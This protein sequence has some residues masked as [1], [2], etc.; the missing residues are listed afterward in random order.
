MSETPQPIAEGNQPKAVKDKNCEYCGQAFT[1]S[2]LGRHLD[3]YIKEKNPKP[4][5]GIHDVDAIR[6]LRGNITRRQPRGS[7]GARR[8][9]STPGSTPKPT[10]GKTALG[11]DSDSFKADSA[12]NKYPFAASWEA[13]GVIKDTPGK[14]AWDASAPQDANKRSGLSRNVSKQMAQ[15]AQFDIKQ[16]LTDAMDTAKAAELALRELVSSWRAAKQQTDR[17][18]T[19][20]D[21]DPLALDFPSLAIHCLL[22]PPTLFSSTQ[23]PT[24][25]SWSLSTPGKREYV[26]L[27][28]FFQEEFKA[29]KATHVS[30][31]TAV[32]GEMVYPSAFAV[33][34]SLP[35]QRKSEL[36]HLELARGVGRMHKQIDKM[37]DEQHNLKQ[38]N[39]NLKSHIDQLNRL[40]Q[41][42][43][44]KILTPSTIPVDRDVI[45]Y[46]E[47]SVIGSRLVGYEPEDRHLDLSTVVAKSIERW[48]S[49]IASTREAASGMPAQRPLEQAAAQTPAANSQTATS[50]A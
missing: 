24:S 45:A 31:T 22:P 17:N 9:N 36:W 39:A 10:A 20:F 16:K 50:A 28:A 47:Q 14:N 29:W 44:Y 23:H 11:Q 1:S 3:L 18:S 26:A 6:K 49:V 27:Q 34:E 8:D 12:A 7:L 25:T 2:S 32:I 48:K 5:D 21:F 42:R 46:H 35:V 30:A 38:E 33:W 4:P 15:K 43:E 13:T 37:K 41:P 40:Q 19:P